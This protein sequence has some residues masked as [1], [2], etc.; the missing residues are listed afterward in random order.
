[1]RV[2]L[3]NG[4]LMDKLKSL[5]GYNGTKIQVEIADYKMEL[6]SYWDSG[7]RD[8]YTCYDMNGNKQT[9]RVQ[10]AP[11][12]FWR[13]GETPV[14]V[15]SPDKFLVNHSTFMGKDMGLHVYI[16]PAS[17]LVGML[18]TDK[19]QI[20]NNELFVLSIICSYKSFARPDYYRGANFKQ[21]EIEEYK[22]ILF[23]KGWVNKAGA[24][25]PAGRNVIEVA[26]EGRSDKQSFTWNY[27]K[28]EI[29]KTQ[30]A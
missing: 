30:E 26:F 20:S 7:S 22:R 6:R 13:G 10:D 19:P 23:E 11:L 17:V 25:T 29:I 15:P 16:H 1:M 9:L 28:E 2:Y 24:I 12:P 4:Q 27:K 5:T 18:P 14:Y 3:S 8:V 21:A